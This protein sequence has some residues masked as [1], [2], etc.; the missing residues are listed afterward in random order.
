[1]VGTIIWEAEKAAVKIK[2]GHIHERKRP[3]LKRNYQLQTSSLE[4]LGCMRWLTTAHAEEGITLD[5]E[6]A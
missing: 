4:S 1:M 2:D 6:P 5:L 3:S